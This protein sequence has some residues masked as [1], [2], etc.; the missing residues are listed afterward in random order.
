LKAAN[1]CAGICHSL[2]DRNNHGHAK[3]FQVFFDMTI[4]TSAAVSHGP[5]VFS[6]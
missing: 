5:H 4:K 1:F 2:A 6:V 3:G